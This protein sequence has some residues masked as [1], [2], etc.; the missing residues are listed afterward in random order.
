MTMKKVTVYR[1]YLT[2]DI[3]DNIR[4]NVLLLW[5]LCI[6]IWHINGNQ[7]TDSSPKCFADF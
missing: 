3:E 5:A 2:E 4:K 7:L 1:P 6:H